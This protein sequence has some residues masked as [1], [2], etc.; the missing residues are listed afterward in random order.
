MTGARWLTALALWLGLPAARALSVMELTED[1]WPTVVDGSK[2][3]L[4]MFYTQD[5]GHCKVLE[6]EYEAAAEALVGGDDVVLARLDSD[7]HVD[8]ADEYEIDGAPIFKWFPQGTTEPEPFYYVHYSGRMGNTLLKMIGERVPGFSKQLPPLKNYVTKLSADDFDGFVSGDAHALVYLYS[9][10]AERQD[11]KL[12]MDKVGKTFE[13]DNVKLAKLPIERVYER[14]IADKY[15][16]KDYPGWLFFSATG[17]WER[18]HGADDA[19]SLVGYINKKANLQRSVGGKLATGAGK[20]DQ[21]EPLVG[22]PVTLELVAEANAVLASLD[23][24]AAENGKHY[25]KVMEKILDK[26]AG[27]VAAEIKRLSGMLDKDSI[28]PEKR[29]LFM[30]RKDILES[31]AKAHSAKTEL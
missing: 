12:A 27:Y 1:S 22:K 10:F 5:C 9:P 15:E 26:G 19:L 24:P 21:M 17:E 30:V 16:I 6:P 25:V 8:V 4:V 7:V 14:D 28:S 13:T 23:G 20:V 2:N 3:V 11:T 18:Y 31:F 29:M